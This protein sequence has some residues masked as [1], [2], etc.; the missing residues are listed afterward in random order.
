MIEN[1]ELVNVELLNVK[2]EP[3]CL[4]VVDFDEGSLQNENGRETCLSLRERKK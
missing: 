2:F 1:I 4:N 3:T